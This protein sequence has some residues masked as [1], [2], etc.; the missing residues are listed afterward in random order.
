[1]LTLRDRIVTYANDGRRA[2]EIV[3]AAF[4]NIVASLRCDPHFRGVSA[5]DLGLLL[6]DARASLYTGSHSRVG[7]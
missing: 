1:V 2:Y 5:F 7:P 4:A 3:D 6:A